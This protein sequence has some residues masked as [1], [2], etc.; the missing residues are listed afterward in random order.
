MHNWSIPGKKFTTPKDWSEITIGKY[1]EYQSMVKAMQKDFVKIFDLKDETEI[2][3]VTD[4]EIFTVYPEYY[5]KI[6]C[7]WSGLTKGECLKIDKG[8]IF[9]VYQYLNKALAANLSE[10][11]IDRFEFKGQIYLFPSSV[12]DINGNEAKMANETFGAMIYAFQQDKILDDISKSKFDALGSQM[13]ILCRPEGEEYDPDK[14]RERG[15][16][17]QDLPMEIVWQFSFFLT[18][19]GLPLIATTE[20]YSK[21]EQVRQTTN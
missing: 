5:I 13:A 10:R 3:E 11:K 4:I 9:S 20:D 16:L 12:K 7:F 2:S 18:R 1:A 21:Q 8:D 6:I 14:T 19:L 17:F 15:R